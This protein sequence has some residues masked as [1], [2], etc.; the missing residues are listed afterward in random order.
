VI[1]L[2]KNNLDV[3]RTCA[4]L[5]DIGKPRCWAKQKRWSDHINYTY[6]VIK[7]GLGEELAQ[8][9]RHHHTGQ[10]YDLADHPQTELEKIICIA[11]NLSSGADRREEPQHGTPM[12]KPPLH[13]THVLSKGNI[14]RQE[15]D[16]ANLE[17]TTLQ[18][19]DELRRLR[20]VFAENKKS[21]YYKLFEVLSK[22]R[23]E[24]IPADTRSP[25]NDVSLWDHLKLTAAFS[26]CIW[27]D[28]GYRGDDLGK[29]EFALISGDADKISRFVNLSSRLP[30]LNARSEKIRVATEEAC[31]CIR[32]VLGPECLIFAGGGGILAVSSVN[33]AEKVAEAVKSS[34]EAA[35]GG[36]VTM[37]INFLNSNGV[38]TQR[39]FGG[40]W[41]EA[42]WLM[43]Q[44]KSERPVRMF[45]NIPEEVEPCD[46]CHTRPVSHEDTGKILPYDASPR[47]EK[48]CEFCWRLRK[49]GLGV[50]LDQ[51]KDQSNFVAI[52]RADG[53]DVGKVLGGD[54]LEGF[55]KVATPS[56]LS[57]M[58]RQ[59]HSICEE[60]LARVTTQAGGRSLIAG[61]DD[62]LAIVPGEQSLPTASLVAA[63]FTRGMANACT[64][65]AG[66]AVFRYDLPVYAGLEAADALLQ[67][68]KGNRNKD[69]VTFAIIG[70]VGFTPEELDNIKHGPWR[71]SELKEILSL[72]RVMAE[73]G[74]ASTQIRRIAATAKKDP[75]LAEILIK[76]LMGRGERGK[77]VSWSEGQRFLSYLESGMLL[78]AFA[79][80]NTFKKRRYEVE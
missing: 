32:D 61:G 74:I 1:W 71:W 26:T 60:T 10:S 28:G 4:L 20:S 51:L 24:G 34:F 63:E 65:S 57:T 49:E 56:R 76:S 66:V 79:I 41:K 36:L 21:G 53:D 42:Q 67:I 38:R 25:I 8:I 22:S 7:E 19:V 37:T 9:A 50:S 18:I 14:N 6:D 59:I 73:G 72:A 80:Y 23:L 48:L 46:V 35:T 2:L 29:Y 12:P 40:L 27:L 70:G 43:Q 77:G 33:M 11:D 58:S 55:E 5:H 62:L 39:E 44:K 45:E 68:A 64:M 3:L 78:D 13:L 47:P 16:S 69:S 30:D 52:I 75:A 31:A 54:K 15:I 17:Y